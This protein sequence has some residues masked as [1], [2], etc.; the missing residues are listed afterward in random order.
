MEPAPIWYPSVNC[1]PRRDGARPD[2]IV[3]H[4]TAMNSAEAARDWLCAPASQVSAHFVI[5]EDGRLWQLVH[6]ADRAWHAGQ[7]AWGPISDVNSHS[8]GIE[9][10]NTG[11]HPFPDPQMRATE[12]LLDHLMTRWHIPAERVVGHSDTALGRKIDPGRRFDWRRLAR[13]GRS[14]WPDSTASTSLCEERFGHDA[15]RFGYDYSP[16]RSEAVR[17]AVRMRFRPHASGPL[18]AEDCAIMADLAHR[19]PVRGLP[20]PQSSR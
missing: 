19:F 11:A 4:Y 10:G 12:M 17:N 1:G 5:A 16:E 3:L 13:G 7:G 2:M 20:A 8:I 9:L 18:C 14:I 6:E 15:R